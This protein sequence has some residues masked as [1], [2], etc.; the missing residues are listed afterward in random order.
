MTHFESG[1][2]GSSVCF[3]RFRRCAGGRAVAGV[4]YR[5]ADSLHNLVMS[6]PS[7]TA[8]RGHDDEY[9]VPA[10]SIGPEAGAQALGM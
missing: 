4:L 3:V 9:G 7:H 5:W 6:A 1:D 2:A 8:N 10:A